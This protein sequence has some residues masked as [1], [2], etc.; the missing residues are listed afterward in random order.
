[1]IF[2][3]RHGERAD[4]IDDRIASDIELIHDPPITKLG[5][6]QS[7][8]AGMK[9]QSLVQEGY[10]SGLLSTPNPQ[11]VFVSSPFIRCLQTAYHMIKSLDPKDIYKETIFY[12]EGIGEL[13][14][15]S[16]FTDHILDKL[17]IR[18]KTEEEVKKLVPYKIQEGF[19]KSNEH[20]IRPGYPENVGSGYER[21]D[22]CYKEIMD[23]FM[24]ELN[25]KNDKVLVL[26]T[27]AFGISAV[28]QIHE[29][30]FFTDKGTDYTT[31][32]QIFYDEKARGKGRFLLKLYHKHILDLVK[33]KL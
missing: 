17:Y 12:E 22:L 31:F 4:Q 29:M 23:Y 19:V 10:K 1:M 14:A 2:T 21:F 7:Y 26:V 11:Y 27:H 18:H 9:I 32:H 8:S 3:I 16:L 28:A 25:Q 20:V 5:H 33:P 24:R 6:L 15:E 30:I 13:M